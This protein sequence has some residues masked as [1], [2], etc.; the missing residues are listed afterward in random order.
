MMKKFTLNL[1]AVAVCSL[2]FTITMGASVHAVE[3]TNGTV[4]QDN[5]KGKCAILPDWIC[6]TSSSTSADPGQTGIFMILKWVL[7]LLSAGIGIA[8]VG[9]L[10][11]AGILYSSAGGGQEQVTKAKKLITDTVIGIVAYALM[12]LALNWLVPGGVIG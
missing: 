6:S 1:V 11:Y 8:A 4:P 12:F 9:T 2:L 10:V 7:Q 3:T 5:A